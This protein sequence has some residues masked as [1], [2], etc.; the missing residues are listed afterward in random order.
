MESQLFPGLAFGSHLWN[1]ERSVVETSVN[2]AYQKGIRRG[3]GMR[4]RDS[5]A[6]RISGFVE[7]SLT[8]KILE[9]KF[10]KRATESRNELVRGLA[11]LIVRRSY[12]GY[13]LD[14]VDGNIFMCWLS[15]FV[16]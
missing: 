11:L 14:M 2:T 8:M 5:I 13:G 3:L 6:E 1:F 4:Q 15:D 7:A 12:P 9:A 16:C 10:L